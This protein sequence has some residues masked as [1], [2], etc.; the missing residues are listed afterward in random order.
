MRPRLHLLKVDTPA[1]GLRN[2][3]CALVRIDIFDRLPSPYGLVR[4][5]V[6]PDH[7]SIKRI[8]RAFARTATKP[9]VR[10]FGNV[11][12]GR[13]I[14]VA[15]LRAHYHSIIYT[16]G[17]EGF[18]KIGIPGQQS[19]QAGRNTPLMLASRAG[20]IRAARL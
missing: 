11:S 6:A 9:G 16:V 7:Q 15:D 10:F 13:D 14:S 1:R 2:A 12:L 18:R 8:E 3:T 17:N 20:N 5:G 19:R 4:S